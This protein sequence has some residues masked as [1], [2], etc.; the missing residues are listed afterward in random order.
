MD[1]LWPHLLQRINMVLS[2][3]VTGTDDDVLQQEMKKAYVSFVSTIMTTGVQDFLISNREYAPPA[4]SG[5]VTDVTCLPSG[6]KGEFENF[7]GSLLTLVNDPDR[8]NQKSAINLLYRTVAIWATNP[9][10][11]A[12]PNYG[13]FANEGATLRP[14]TAAPKKNP[15]LNGSDTNGSHSPKEQGLPGYEQVVY[16]RIIPLLFRTIMDQGLKLKDGQSQLVSRSGMPR[17]L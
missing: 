11:A 16:D 5:D 9:A 14:H 4:C 15:T 6:N 17:P 7:I 3:P 12:L 10:V 1:E 13:V 8:N 2:L